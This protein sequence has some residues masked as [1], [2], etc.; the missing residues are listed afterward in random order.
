M[1][2]EKKKKVR[3]TSYEILEYKLDLRDEDND[4]RK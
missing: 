3:H 2:I 4:E 1:K